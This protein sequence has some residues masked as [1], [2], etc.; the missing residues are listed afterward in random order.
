M[1]GLAD[2]IREAALKRGIDPNVAIKVANSEGGLND[3]VR[4]S[5]FRKDGVRDPSYGP[6]Q[7]LIG[8]GQTGFP[9]G[10][11]NMF[12]EK[13]GLDPRDPAN[14]QAGID[15]ALDTAANKGWGQWY[16]AKRVGLDNFAGINGAVSRTDTPT[17]V[18][19]APA[20]GGQPGMAPAAGPP[21]AGAFGDVVAPQAAPDFGTVIANYLQRSKQRNDDQQ[22][23]ATRRQA[24]LSV[25]NPFR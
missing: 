8:G 6:F 18:A 9:S 16:G 12:M 13:T 17:V 3:P 11:G 7:L 20:I 5:D 22:A 10:L 24:L 1:A 4:Q 23:E 15:F 21:A 25:Q 19:S 14:A 2:Y